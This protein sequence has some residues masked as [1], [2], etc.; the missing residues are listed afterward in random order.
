MMGNFVWPSG[1]LTFCTCF[2]IGVALGFHYLWLD[3]TSDII[4]A[5]AFSVATNLAHILITREVILRVHNG[6]MGTLKDGVDPDDDTLNP[7]N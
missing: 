2:K 5:F 4:A 3:R 6:D 1:A 7:F